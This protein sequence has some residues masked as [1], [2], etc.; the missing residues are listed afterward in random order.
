M[1]S[2]H[3]SALWK[4]RVNKAYAEAHNHLLVGE[5]MS[6]DSVC[7]EL[8]CRSFHFG[9][10]VNSLKNV[11]VGDLG[12]RIVPWMQIEIINVLPGDYDYRGAELTADAEG[13]VY[14]TDRRHA[15]P[16]A[17]RQEPRH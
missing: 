6:R 12:R 8:E 5:V 16:I 11:A 15:C 3:D 14:L 2:K 1:S 10:L 17:T 9:R 13:N 7:V 4:V